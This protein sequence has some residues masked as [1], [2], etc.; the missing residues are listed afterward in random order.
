MS[1]ESKI[2]EKSLKYVSYLQKGNQPRNHKE[3]LKYFVMFLNT[4]EE[5]SKNKKRYSI[6]VGINTPE[7]KKEVN[8]LDDCGFVLHHLYP[9]I[10]T[11]SDLEKFDQYFKI[12]TKFL[13][14]SHVSS[15]SKTYIIDFENKNFKE[16][17]EESFAISS[18]GLAALNARLK[19]SRIALSSSDNE[20]FGDK[21]SIRNVFSK[22]VSKAIEFFVYKGQFIQASDFLN[23]FLDTASSSIEKSVLVSSI[24]SHNASY[25]LRSRAELNSFIE[26]Y[27][28]LISDEDLEYLKTTVNSEAGGVEVHGFSFGNGT[29]S[30]NSTKDKNVV[31]LI[32]FSIPS[33]CYSVDSQV[34]EIDDKLEIMLSPVSAFWA[35]PM[36]RI[37]SGWNIANMGWSHFCDIEPE[38]GKNYTHILIA[39]REL[40]TPDVKLN[41]NSYDNIDF[42]EK[43]ALIGRTY[44]P[45]KEFVVK[46]LLSNLTAL[47]KHIEIDKKD[48][49]VNMF[50]NYFVQH[51]NE[52]TRENIHH[53]LY[54]ITNPDSY[55]K[56][57]TRF[58]ERLNSV[59]LADAF[60]DIRELMLT[61]K[62]E[63][64]KSLKEFVFRCVDLFVKHNIENHGGYKYLWKNDVNGKQIPCREPETQPYIFSHL[65]AIFDFMGIQIS[66]EVES[67][68]GE[69][70]FLVSFTNSQNKL[71]KLCVELKLAHAENVEKG[72]TKQLPAYLKGERCKYGV[73]LVLWYKCELFDRPTKYNSLDELEAQLNKINANKNISNL[74]ID[75]TKPVSPSKLR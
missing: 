16:K 35:D 75:C 59:N 46:T 3:A 65:R 8:L 33:V 70:D 48:I 63:T 67:S 29:L 1:T 64:E 15:I 49:N 69:V 43:E 57:L 36:F 12:T 45:H 40:Y 74:I 39:I 11:Y 60:I 14:S 31:T 72:L 26:E 2:I 22:Y 71:L 41:E 24:V 54:A 28:E 27:E 4:I 13:E 17:I 38:E 6:K 30:I 68:N 42:S 19:F 55:S 51:I 25:N 53:K 5:L 58:V 37:M 44:Y 66:R 9:I 50:S 34:I 56:T 73:Y 61:T 10:L 21:N 18:Q 47:Q 20:I 7:G 32:R 52:I 23:E 62:I